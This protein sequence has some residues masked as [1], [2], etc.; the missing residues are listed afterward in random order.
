MVKRPKQKGTR[1]SE[2]TRKKKSTAVSKPR[3]KSAR[4]KES[5]K[6]EVSL[7]KARSEDSMEKT[8]PEAAEGVSSDTGIQET[9]ASGLKPLQTE[10]KPM[11]DFQTVPETALLS[12]G[13]RETK[14]GTEVA[15]SD[16]DEVLELL[17]FRLA[18][19]EYAVDILM[20]REIIRLVDI[21]RVPRRPSFVKGIISL[22]GTI[23]PV[24]DLRTRLGLAES[25]S[26]RSTRIL[27]VGLGRGLIGVIADSV[28]EVVKVALSHIEPPPAAG[29]GSSSGHLKGVTRVNGRLLILLDLEK[30]IAAD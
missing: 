20:I 24:I 2:T 16:V 13:A 14:K 19:E 22:R 12:A 5:S 18:D 23:I 29:G 17:A 30:V 6:P 7:Q 4:L 11:N 3:K 21:T 9:S 26:D 28:T 25:A 15:V 10:E 27:V 1:T 8:G